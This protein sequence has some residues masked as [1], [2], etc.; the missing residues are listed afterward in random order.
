MLWALREVP[1]ATTGA[2]LYMLVY[3]HSP[4]GPLG[5]LKESWTGESDTG[6]NL[7][8]PVEDYPLDLRSILSQAAE[9]AQSHTNAAQQ[10]C[11]PLQ[12]E[13]PAEKISKGRSG[14]CLGPREHR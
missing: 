3:G 7:A 14:H 12:S 9:F 2:S 6:A 4:R 13:G 1:N 11:C 10:L 5:V 8:Q